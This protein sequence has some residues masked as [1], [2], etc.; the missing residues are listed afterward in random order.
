MNSDSLPKS[1]SLGIDFVKFLAA[2]LV[3][4]IHTSPLLSLSWVCNGLLVQVIAR[5]AVPFFFMSAGYLFYRKISCYYSQEKERHLNWTALFQYLKKLGRIYVVWSLIYITIFL[6]IGEPW[7]ELNFE[8]YFFPGIYGVLWFLP[9]LGFGILLLFV[10]WSSGRL[11]WCLVLPVLIYLSKILGELFLKDGVVLQFL[12]SYFWQGV[13][14]VAAGALLTRWNGK[15][16]SRVF[17]ICMFLAM[18]ALILLMIALKEYYVI[19]V[20]KTLLLLFSGV[21]I[22]LYL[23]CHG[24]P[25]YFHK[26]SGIWLREMSLLIYVLHGLVKLCLDHYFIIENSFFYFFAILGGAMLCATL[27]RSAAGHWS[28][29]NSLY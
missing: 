7:P 25:K 18:Q 5:N 9:A 2:I 8:S 1:A 20:D 19:E 4:C 6:L 21:C 13:Y 26:I 11:S 3:V 14:F 24:V 15:Q 28:L 16:L 23:L 29:F 10:P 17:L 12:Q 22:L 27:L